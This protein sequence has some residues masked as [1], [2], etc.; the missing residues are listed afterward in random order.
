[1]R[2]VNLTA[3]TNIGMM[4]YIVLITVG[5]LTTTSASRLLIEP[6][7]F[8]AAI[9]VVL[10]V[11]L[12]MLKNRIEIEQVWGGGML[13]ITMIIGF[14][15]AVLTESLTNDAYRIAIDWMVLLLG[16]LL[17]DMTSANVIG[18]NLARMILVYGVLGLGVT[19]IIGGIDF[20][21]L[22]NFNYEY[23]AD[24]ENTEN[25]YSLGMSNYMAMIAIVSVYLSVG[26]LNKFHKILYIV[27]GLMFLMLSFLA[28]GRGDS[29]AGLVV[30]GFFVIYKYGVRVFGLSAL[31]SAM[32]FLGV[33]STD[34]F[35]DL[36][37]V[38][39][40][41]VVEDVT[42][43]RDILINQAIDLLT[44]DSM[45]SLVGC[46]F[47][48]FQKYY[49]YDYGKYPHN[50]VLEALITFG[51]PM[52]L[53]FLF[54]VMRGL[55]K[56]IKSVGGV[57]LFILLFLYSFIVALKSNAMTANWFLVVAAFMFLINGL[58]GKRAN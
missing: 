14:G 16:L 52:V 3:A 32:I 56:Y 47:S 26:T 50:V 33:N 2:K 24:L 21:P 9:M 4:S 48:Y 7:R 58:L 38:Q 6:T 27:L 22:P 29:I 53:T 1:M 54:F 35:N 44:E 23:I 55:T 28:G 40:F 34:E 39:R 19:L 49:S 10:I 25:T 45:C 36:L 30:I 15:L 8:A 5:L 13:T 43:G 46:G 20:T 31:F 51:V 41:S 37:I 17:F 11:A 42:S 12:R 57:D 18:M